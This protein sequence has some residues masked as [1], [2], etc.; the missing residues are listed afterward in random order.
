MAKNVARINSQNILADGHMLVVNIERV[1]EV[2][3]DEGKFTY[4]D[5][6]DPY[7]QVGTEYLSVAPGFTFDFE[8]QKFFD[9][10]GAEV[11]PQ[12]T[13]EFVADTG[14]PVE[15]LK[16]QIDAIEAAHPIT[17]RLQ[18]ELALIVRS[19]IQVVA[20]GQPPIY[21]LEAANALNDEIV[22]L[23]EQ[24]LALQTP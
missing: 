19:L 15:S 23:R 4:R 21:G 20:P 10:N 12:I 14:G 18:R 5:L 8:L 24:L 17:P 1:S 11:I 9:F 3:Q 7:G 13:V 16:A 2:P 22:A 6:G